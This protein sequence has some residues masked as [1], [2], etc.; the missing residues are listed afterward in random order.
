LAP[1]SRWRRKR[2][3]SAAVI[4]RTL[5]IVPLG[6]KRRPPAKKRAHVSSER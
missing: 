6:D 3:T 1:T 4:D 2:R 5:A